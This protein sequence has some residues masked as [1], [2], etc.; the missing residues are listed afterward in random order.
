[1]A[2][3]LLHVLRSTSLRKA[4]P[5]LAILTLILGGSTTTMAKESSL[6]KLATVEGITE[7]ELANGLKV[8]L[9]PDPSRP[10]VTV[11]VTVLVGSRHE[12]YGEAGM[13][14]LLEHMVFKGTPTHPQIPKVLQ[15]HGAR[16]NGTTW[17]DRTNYFET[18]PASE[19][20]LE[21]ALRL[22]ADRLVNSLIRA[23]DLASEM[24]V[25]RNEFER[26]ENSPSRV[27]AQKMM[28]AAFEW[29]NY[30]KST[31]GNRSDIERVPVEKLRDFYRRYYQPDNT[32]LVVAGRFD[33]QHA[34]ESI[35]KYFG[36]IPRPERKLETTYTEEPPQDGERIVTLRRVGDIAI[37][38][39]VFHIPAGPHPEF[40]AVEILESI[41]TD[42]PSGRLYKALVE[43]GKAA[44]ISGVA[45][46]WHDPGVL[47]IL[48]E[49]NKG[50]SP[51]VVLDTMLVTLEEVVRN[52]VTEQE[53]ERARARLL[54]QRELAAGD[55]STLAVELSE[56]AAQG[57]WR[58]YFLHRDRLEEV[59][60][61]DVQKVAA[62]YLERHNRTVGMYLPA[63]KAERAEIPATPDVAA[64]LKD[65]QGRE[66]VALGEAFDVS[67]ASIE[68]RTERLRI[69]PGIDVALLPKQTRGE[70]VQLRLAL[71]YGTPES[72]QEY[73]TAAEFLPELMIRGTEKLNREELQDALDRHRARLSAVGSPGVAMFTI[74]TKRSELPAVLD[75]FRQVLR[76]PALSVEELNV[77]KRRQLT[78]LEQD[79]N[80]PRALASRQLSRQLAP[81]E[82][83]DVRY[84][85]T[86]E[87]EIDRVEALKVEHVRQLYR[88]FLSGQAGQLAIVGDFDA[89]ETLPKLKELFA[90]WKSSQPYVRIARPAAS[91]WNSDD[92][93]IQTPDKANAIYYAGLV[94][95]LRDS[96]TDYAALVLG[97]YILGAGSLS[98]RLGDRVRQKEGLSYGVGSTFRA[99]P[100]DP[101]ATLTL[102]AIT[103]P[104]NME[105]VKSSIREEVERLLRD[106]PTAE[107][108]ERAKEGYL[109]R[110]QVSRTDDSTL[111]QTLISTLYVGRTMRYYE[112]FESQVEALTPSKVVEALRR[113]IDPDRIAVIEA[114]DFAPATVP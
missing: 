39:T 27:L 24:T 64:L 23:E 111:A 65:Y 62:K 97:D 56:W 98:S 112:N 46:A 113:H 61:E 72:L 67:P 34:L 17:V 106:G 22:E 109:Q 93:I 104:A 95:P 51:E 12:G 89:E 30:G 4:G 25:V 114:G 54:K 16:F 53:V 86:I 101:R 44:S 26:G 79:S 103:N 69:E 60:A 2:R 49:V 85:P 28:A 102:Y 100:L 18:L 1:M 77:L 3:H 92:Q 21:F 76:E 75:L 6:R 48:A 19:E 5:L 108:L 15:E 29:H 14:H 68:A 110:Q 80:D 91:E 9:V 94:F 38:G 10:T 66:N 33:E 11:N 74:Q 83:D 96:D 41:L 36:S 84:L 50:N 107:E 71:R 35:Q 81:Y 59:T 82:E 20:N 55:T 13:A 7:Y 90:G 63:E 70:V 88:D 57:D 45:Y 37:V 31:I 47:R 52:G 73:A 32:V 8:L 43:S 78:S 40:P 58:L 87:E 42:A 105:K 99:D